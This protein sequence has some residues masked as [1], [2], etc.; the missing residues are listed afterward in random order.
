[1]KI[2]LKPY[3]MHD[4]GVPVYQ[5]TPSDGFY[6]HTF[7]DVSPWSPSGRY[8]VALRLPF[9]DREPGPD[10]PAEIF[11]LDFFDLEIR[12]VYTTTGW[13]MQTA[14]HQMWGATDRYLY[15]NDKR[16]GLPVGVRYDLEQDRAEIFDYPFYQ[17][18]PD[19]SHAVS[20]SLIGINKTQP[21]YGVSVAPEFDRPNR[22]GAPDDDGFWRVDLAT[23]ERSLLVS[24]KQVADLLEEAGEVVEGT[25]YGF[26]VKF[27]P[28]Q[29]RLMLVVRT[30]GT[31]KGWNPM[32]FTCNVDGSDLRLVIPYRRWKLGGHHPDWHPNG[33]RIVM[34]LAD[35]SGALRFH[36][37]G[38][39]GTWER[40]IAPSV[41]ASG[42]PTYSENGRFLITDAYPKEPVCKDGL[43]PIRLID[44]EKNTE[45]TLLWIWT[46]G[47]YGG[48]LRLDPHPAWNR[49]GDQIC[50][51]GAPDG[52][53][54]LFMADLS[55]R[56]DVIQK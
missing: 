25:Y 17:V 6:I 51:N 12:H 14:A 18:A 41:V 33:E 20:P 23:G 9:Q 22:P 56:P 1:V 16:D 28:Q 52:A 42:H 53:R 46:L 5:I 2:E 7:Y 39:D 36:E 3:T 10:D 21:G 45:E 32:L 49:E 54:Q 24:F 13:G 44:I 40:I 47:I 15:F 8:L 31:E 27:N 34:N 29:T 38:Y 26:H 11:L 19:G 55:S 35:A 50:F 4:P 48:P 43:V 30:V 37:F